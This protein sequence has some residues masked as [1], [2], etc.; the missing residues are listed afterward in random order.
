MT[1]AVLEEFGGDATE[2]RTVLGA[3][4]D[5]LGDFFGLLTRTTARKLNDR[6]ESRGRDT[7][8]N[9]RLLFNGLRYL[10]PSVPASIHVELYRV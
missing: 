3:D 8:A 10:N 9:I 6:L 2:R 5:A 7:L 1:P 4:L